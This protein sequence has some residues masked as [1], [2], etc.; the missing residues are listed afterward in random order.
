MTGDERG[1][2]WIEQI[3]VNDSNIEFKVDTG[4]E[5]DVLPLSVYHRLDLRSELVPTDIT[6]RAFGGQ[7]IVPMGMC[8]LNCSYRNVSIKVKFAVVDFN[9]FPLLG[10]ATCRSFGLVPHS[11]NSH[12]V[13]E[14]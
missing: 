1:A 14:L 3:R 13:K 6:L 8:T 12:S 9:M 4:A 10:L 7:Q 5:I 2:P 11:E